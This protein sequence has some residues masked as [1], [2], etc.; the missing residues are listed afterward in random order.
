MSA[1]RGVALTV[2]FLCELS[3]L[4]ALAY[5]G[6]ETGAGPWAWVLGIG[7]PALAAVTWGM[8]VAPKARRPV[9]VPTRLAIELVLFGAAA[10]GLTVAGQPVLAVVFAVAASVTSLVNAF[11]DDGLR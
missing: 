6:F 8:F 3:M 7:A 9:S 10:I 4:A 1:L 11:T 2:R 5:W